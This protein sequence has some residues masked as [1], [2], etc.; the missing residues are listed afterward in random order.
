MYKDKQA[1]AAFAQKAMSIYDAQRA[2]LE[3]AHAGQIAA[4]DPDSGDIFIGPTLGKAN[5]LAYQKY[6]DK[7][8]YFVRIGTPAAAIPLRTW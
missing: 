5:D 7:W 8:L 1:Q 4:I 3:A 2:E 6:P